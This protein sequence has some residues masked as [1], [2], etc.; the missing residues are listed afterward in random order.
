MKKAHSLRGTSAGRVLRT[1]MDFR[2]PLPRLRARGHAPRSKAEKEHPAGPARRCARLS[3][4]RNTPENDERQ[5]TVPEG[6]ATLFFAPAALI[7]CPWI[8]GRQIGGDTVTVYLDTAFCGQR[9]RQ[10]SPA[11]LGSISGARA[12]RRGRFLLAAAL[13]GLYAAASLRARASPSCARAGMKAVLASPAPAF[14]AR[15][16]TVRFALLFCDQRRAGRAAMLQ[17]R[18]AP[19]AHD[20]LLC[21]RAACSAP[22]AAGRFCFWPRSLC[23]LHRSDFSR[24]YRSR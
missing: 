2:L 10:L 7:L 16:Q 1:G 18:T 23:G 9:L 3:A 5:V 20:Q 15:R 14:G 19:A 21:F 13:G 8:T 17:P 12:L 22:S 24:R 11:A 4:P 6:I